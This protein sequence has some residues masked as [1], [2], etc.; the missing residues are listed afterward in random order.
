MV[1]FVPEQHVTLVIKVL[2]G[3]ECASSQIA[4]PYGCDNRLTLRLSNK[5]FGMP[6]ITTETEWRV[7]N[8][9]GTAVRG[10]SFGEV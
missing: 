9:Y 4:A 6:L 1:F 8:T 5:Y 7:I 2:K 3:V 10:Y